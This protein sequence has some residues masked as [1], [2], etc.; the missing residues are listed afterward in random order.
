MKRILISMIL[1]LVVLSACNTNIEETEPDKKTETN[2]YISLSDESDH[3]KLNGY[4]IMMTPEGY[5]AG[6]G[7][8]KMKDEDKQS[9]GFLSYDVYGSVDGEEIKFQSGSV[10]G[11][12]DITEMTIGTIEG[13]EESLREFPKLDEIYM[14][15][16][17]NDEDTDG[18]K[19]EKIILYNKDKSGYEKMLLDS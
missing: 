9:E 16:T 8:L 12:T 1:L 15:I 19:E 11:D 7:I 4:E 6:N 10:S 17:W 13:D 5:K 18:D 3:W 14:T 2:Y